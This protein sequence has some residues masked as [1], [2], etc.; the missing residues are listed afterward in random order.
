MKLRRMSKGHADQFRQLTEAVAKG[1]AAIVP[2][3]QIDNV[4]RATFAAID[5][6]HTGNAICLD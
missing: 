5:S 3:E 6:A 4:M 1:G 2:F